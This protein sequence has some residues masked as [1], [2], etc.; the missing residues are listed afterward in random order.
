MN[1]Q[2]SVPRVS[3][4]FFRE[5]EGSICEFHKVFNVRVHGTWVNNYLNAI[6]TEMKRSDETPRL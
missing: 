6:T 5:R 1:F 2:L 3:Q 4:S